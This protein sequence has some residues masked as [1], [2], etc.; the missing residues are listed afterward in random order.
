MISFLCQ[1]RVGEILGDRRRVHSLYQLVH[2][3][4]Y[5]RRMNVPSGASQIK[6]LVSHGQVVSG[7]Q[8]GPLKLALER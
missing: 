8:S 2:S 3:P 7:S 1:T 5:G 4:A 6:I